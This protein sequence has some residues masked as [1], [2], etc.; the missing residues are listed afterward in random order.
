MRFSHPL[1]VFDRDVAGVVVVIS[2]LY[3]TQARVLDE[4]R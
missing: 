4:V 2:E 1:L 3:L